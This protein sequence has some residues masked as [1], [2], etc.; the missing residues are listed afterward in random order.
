MRWRP[1]L[2][3][4]AVVAVALALS[5]ASAIFGR[6]G[7]G[8]RPDPA[9]LARGT[10]LFGSLMLLIITLRV[11]GPQWREKL[12][13]AP[14][15][16]HDLL[17]GLLGAVSGYAVNAF[18]VAAR[19]VAQGPAELKAEAQAKMQWSSPFA[20]IPLWQVLPLALFV[21]LWEEVLFR[22]FALGRFREGFGTDQRGTAQAIALS[23]LF[24]GL[25]HLYQ[26]AMGV[27]QTALLGACFATLTVWRKSLWPAIVAHAA[28]D[29]FG[30]LALRVLKPLAEKLLAG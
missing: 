6:G 9:T 12:C 20:E 5:T 17:F 14:F 30:L 2:E 8:A 18:L 13:L 4:L 1:I 16:P 15:H 27:V 24:F 26:G 23:S 10:L 21:G 25:A 11:K 28:I 7:V 19:L 3:A 22:G 29:T